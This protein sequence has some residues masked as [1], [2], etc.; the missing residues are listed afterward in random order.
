MR[1]AFFCLQSGWGAHVIHDLELIQ[2]DL[3]DGAEV[4]VIGPGKRLRF[5]DTKPHVDYRKR[6]RR[7]AGRL[8]AGLSL[9]EG[10]F[11]YLPIDE[12]IESAPGYEALARLQFPAFAS[13]EELNA[14][15]FE[16][17]D[18]GNAVLSSLISCMQNTAIEPAEHR[19]LVERALDTSIKT[20]LAT[21]NYIQRRQPDRVTL[22]NGRM[23]SFRGILRA[24]QEADVPCRVHERGAT[25]DRI[26]LAENTMPHDVRWTRRD[27]VERWNTSSHSLEEKR[28]IGK[29]FFDRLAA[30][31]ALNGY[32]FTEAQERGVLPFDRN[33][34]K[35]L[36]SIFTSSEFERVALSEYYQYLCHE[37][38]VD[39]ILD[40][41]R[42]LKESGFDGKI[43]V[44]AHP[45]GRDEKPD[46]CDVLRSQVDADFVELI[47]AASPVDTYALLDASD[48]V[49]AF[50]STVAVEATY[51]GKPSISLATSG[52]DELAAVYHPTTREEARALI[53]GDLAVGSLDD[54]LKYGYYRAT[55]GQ[56][57]RHAKPLGD[58]R[59]FSF[60]GKRI[61]RTDWRFWRR[62]VYDAPRSEDRAL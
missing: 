15:R 38:Q 42:M 2:L 13:R 51:R 10:E 11:S 17:H 14:Y 46:I 45:N 60:K 32:A 35:A 49:I 44:R 23:A 3:D 48:K 12:L 53:V 8:R 20:Y 40:V 39:G 4:D 57:M 19:D 31:N 18:C 33:E 58:L 34:T 16:G 25:L 36:Y 37:N 24:C 27:I 41:I 26:L 6:L 50:G 5:N 56:E 21:R 29:A 62:G 59:S 52:Y 47:D 28:E 61:R 7:D 54:C 1:S 55:F 9:I 43:C 30:G 22:F